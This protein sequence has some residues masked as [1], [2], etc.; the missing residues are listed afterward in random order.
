MVVTAVMLATTLVIGT[1]AWGS[2][3]DLVGV[4]ATAPR[5]GHPGGEIFPR[6]TVKAVGQVGTSTALRFYLSADKVKSGSDLPLAGTV[7]VPKLAAGQTYVAKGA[8]TLPREIKLGRLYVLGC[9]DDLKQWAEP[10]EAN[11]CAASETRI[12]ITVAPVTS[13]SLIEAAVGAGELTAEQGLIY[14]VFAAFGDRRLPA[15]YRGDDNEVA[16]DSV[17][18][19]TGRLWPTLSDA[20]RTSLAPFFVPPAAR[21]SWANL[22]GAGATAPS[23]GAEDTAPTD[24][25]D[26]DQLKGD[27]WK[28]VRTAD[29]KVR[30]WWYDD[31][32]TP[33][34]Q[35]AALFMSREIPP[36]WK[37]FKD[38]MGREPPSDANA[39]CF[40]G[41][42]GALDI[43][44]TRWVEKAIALTQAS[45]LGPNHRL[46]CDGTSSYIVFRTLGGPPGKY[47]L[48]HELFHAFQNAFPYFNGE[49]QN[50][51]W[52]DEGSA[53]W[54]VHYV[55]PDSWFAENWDTMMFYPDGEYHHLDDRSY[56]SW[57]FDLYLEKNL[58]PKI[59]PAIYRAFAGALSL[60][61]INQ[62]IGGFKKRW[63]EFTKH[64]WNQEP[65]PSFRQW[66]KGWDA[67]PIVS[68][69]WEGPLC[70]G[71][72]V[73]EELP[74]IELAIGGLTQR[75]ANLP[76]TK[77][78]YL[79]RT[80]YKL[81]VVD[82]NV[83]YLKFNNTLSGLPHAAV[84]AIVTYAD[85]H[86]AYQNW[87]GR[88][89]VEFCRDK[90]AEDVTKLVVM[91]A[92]DD[93]QGKKGLSPSEQPTMRI[94]S[95]CETYRY[96]ILSATWSTHA[97]ADPGLDQCEQFDSGFSQSGTADWSGSAGSDDQPW[98]PVSKLQMSKQGGVEYVTGQ[99]KATTPATLEMSRDGCKPV[100]PSDPLQWVSCTRT[101]QQESPPS[102]FDV[103]S[104]DFQKRTA[105]L[106]GHWSVPS[107]EVGF[108]SGDDGGSDPECW[109][110]S[111]VLFTD[112][113][114]GYT[115]QTQPLSTFTGY[116]PQTIIF[117]G[118]KHFS[119]T[120]FDGSTTSLDYSWTFSIEFIR[121]DDENNPLK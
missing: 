37:A 48:A 106:T 76:A 15:A 20:A 24:P 59:I 50:F 31:P 53:T 87:T 12:E 63:P 95:T 60:P 92:N 68:W 30:I 49:C 4:A 44:L 109:V 79:E 86:T 56:E 38:L 64:A 3:G 117:S 115:K 66:D 103:F 90:P 7:K 28:N 98:P 25:C 96:K 74:P 19:E 62:A 110:L 118:S 116:G 99:I 89:Y 29:G 82:D 35:Q 114:D 100:I 52:F 26:S 88:P 54:A 32:K 78:G 119:R 101:N 47:V 46:I 69:H 81:A 42:D 71:G 2:G 102:F 51:N 121:L 22:P 16:D 108:A 41:P 1:P 57:A 13:R 80:Y 84:G 27:G 94:R 73:Y 23:P 6:A 40:H 11:N 43:Y 107:P 72:P 67:H 14:R 18:E 104:I 97:T 10:D 77:T 83:R 105:T 9:A 55:F 5:Y 61:A 34:N 113:P 33:W 17:M 8:V 93:W 45:D 75:T 58:G 65:I 120:E 70:C 111:D 36:I 112:D 85:G 91:Y 21:S 39:R